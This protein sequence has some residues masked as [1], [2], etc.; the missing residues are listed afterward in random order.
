LNRYII[1][2]IE[3]PEMMMGQTI[4]WY[5]FI[6]AIALTILVTILVELVMS[7]KIKKIDMIGALKEL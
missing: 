6:I 4:K 2:S 7:F 5:S 3:E 1:H